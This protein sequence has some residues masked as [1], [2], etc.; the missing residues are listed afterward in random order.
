[1]LCALSLSCICA[2]IAHSTLWYMIGTSWVLCVV[3]Q[4]PTRTC[5]CLRSELGVCCCIK[6]HKP[7]YRYSLQ[8]HLYVY[9]Y[10]VFWYPY[11][12]ALL[13]VK[14]SA[15]AASSGAVKYKLANVQDSILYKLGTDTHHYHQYSC[16][17]ITRIQYTRVQLYT[18]FHRLLHNNLTLTLEYHSS[19]RRVVQSGKTRMPEHRGHY[20]APQKAHNRH[21]SFCTLIW[22][23]R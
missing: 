13:L 4:A 20:R 19:S 3:Q 17:Q 7:T 2:R 1:M 22:V 8:L 15:A 10:I 5:I 12:L 6:L 14:T 9:E 16:T 18:Y 11:R 21:G 23:D